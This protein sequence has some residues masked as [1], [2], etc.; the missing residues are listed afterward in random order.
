MTMTSGNSGSGPGSDGLGCR[1]DGGC[2]PAS[3]TR[4]PL[5][6]PHQRHDQSGSADAR[7]LRSA[8]PKL[9]VASIITLPFSHQMDFRLGAK[10]SATAQQDTTS[11]LM[12]G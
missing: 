7:D 2:S 6:L 8:F 5:W 11:H 1:S 4:T 12:S 9:L 10:S 3:S